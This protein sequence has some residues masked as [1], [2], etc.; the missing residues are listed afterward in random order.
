MGQAKEGLG[1]LE[2]GLRTVE[3]GEGVSTGPLPAQ[4]TAD[5]EERPKAWGA[6]QQAD[7]PGTGSL[8]AEEPAGPA[9]PIALQDGALAMFPRVCPKRNG[10]SES[11]HI[12]PTE[13][14]T[15]EAFVVQ[16]QTLWG[17]AFLINLSFF[18]SKCYFYFLKLK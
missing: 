3:A 18:G 7:A 16:V 4:R 11:N 14:G 1:V 13:E 12:Q 2:P 8:G 10:L 15:P 6:G 9:Q 5:G 17:L